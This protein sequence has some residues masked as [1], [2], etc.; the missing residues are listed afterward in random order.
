M[1]QIVIFDE[2]AIAIILIFWIAAIVKREYVT[3]SHKIM[4]VLLS[5]ALIAA[6]A[7]FGAALMCNVS[8]GGEYAAGI[9]GGK[10]NSGGTFIANGGTVTVTGG[11]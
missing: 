2:C 3:R 5:L 4:L 7:D 6:F 9:G 10:W 1:Q 8:T 11:S